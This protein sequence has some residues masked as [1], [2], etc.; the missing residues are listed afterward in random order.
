MSYTISKKTVEETPFLYMRR[1]IEH[2]EIAKALGEL[3][4]AVFQYAS[5]N[6]LVFAGPPT[7]R[8][9]DWS[10]SGVTLEAGLPIGAPAKGEGDI[11]VG[12]L[13]A[14]PAASTIHKGPYDDLNKAHSAIEAWIATNALT[15]AGDPYE[16]YLTDPVE[17]PD[18][19]EWLTEVIWPTAE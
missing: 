13:P 15:A 3:L 5:K 16:V 12:T 7:C 11:Q 9:C 2:H 6:G 1:R 14:G 19:A 17:V 18:P 8:Y 10:T 4:P